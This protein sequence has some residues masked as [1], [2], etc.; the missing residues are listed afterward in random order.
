MKALH[1]MHWTDV[2]DDPTMIEIN[3]AT[4]ALR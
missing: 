4:D 1:R 3:V 2:F